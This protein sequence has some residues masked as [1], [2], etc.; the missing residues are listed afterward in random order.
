MTST[1]QARERLESANIVP[2]PESL[3][4]GAWS[5]AALLERVHERRHAV[6]KTDTTFSAGVAEPRPRRGRGPLVGLATAAAVIVIGA[7]FAWAGLTAGGDPP[8]DSDRTDVEIAA[9]WLERWEAG[10]IDGLEALTSPDMLGGTWQG[11]SGQRT[12]HDNARYMAATGIDLAADCI[13]LGD[14]VSCSILTI[15]GLSPGTVIDDS[16]NIFT[17]E[18][19]LVAHI[20]FA[21]PGKMPITADTALLAYRDWL[22]DRH[23]E[24]AAEL[25]ADS[26][27]KLLAETPEAR[28]AHQKYV[29]EFIAESGG[30]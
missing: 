19:G 30:G 11:S 1:Q 22:R 12:F 28:A 3:P 8:R 10:D 7:A 5:S 23:P 9:D 17:I 15:S 2:S 27:L 29:A 18:D 25:F 13:P 21:R 16:T 14:Q 6:T 26:V 4:H 20:Q 24:A